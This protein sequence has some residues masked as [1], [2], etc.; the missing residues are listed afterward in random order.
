MDPTATCSCGR[1]KADATFVVEHRGSNRHTHHR[2]QCGIEWTTTESTVDLSD[3][4]TSEEVLE[5]HRRMDQAG[6]KPLKDLIT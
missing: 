3:P 2:C 6:D 4:V 1:P 5:V